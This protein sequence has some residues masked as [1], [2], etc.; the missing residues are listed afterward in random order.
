MNKETIVVKK[1]NLQQ[2]QV[3]KL[4][5][6]IEMK[7]ENIKYQ[8]NK[9]CQLLH[10]LDSKEPFGLNCLLFTY[11]ELVNILKNKHHQLHDYIYRWFVPLEDCDFKDNKT[12]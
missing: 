8:V 3:D 9:Y 6:I 11:D 1:V 4:N 2:E 7:E 12:L 10:K 5:Q